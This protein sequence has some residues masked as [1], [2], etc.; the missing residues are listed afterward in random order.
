ML[1]E[2]TSHGEPEYELEKL[3]DVQKRSNGKREEFLV[4]YKG[5]PTVSPVDSAA[6]MCHAR[7]APSSAWRVVVF[8]SLRSTAFPAILLL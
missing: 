6:L 2:E 7:D 1:A 5:Y 8:F 4:R 3:M